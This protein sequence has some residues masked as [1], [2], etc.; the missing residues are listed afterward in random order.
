MM[1]EKV[2]DFNEKQ[3]RMIGEI[4]DVFER[5]DA[6]LLE[7]YRVLAIVQSVTR[8]QLRQMLAELG[9][10]AD[11]LMEGIDDLLGESE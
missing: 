8:T 4:V 5:N 11:S 10:Q 2:D 1:E 9:E 6:N 3:A 7:M